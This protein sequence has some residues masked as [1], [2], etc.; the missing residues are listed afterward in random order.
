MNLAELRESLEFLF[1]PAGEI[2]LVMY[3][4]VSTEAGF[5]ARQADITE[6]V[7]V[8][9]RDQFLSFIQEKFMVNQELHFADI[10]VADNRQ[11]SAYYFDLDE[12]PTGLIVMGDLMQDEAAPV[13]DFN[14]DDYESVFGFV[15]LLGNESHKVGLYKKHYPI[16]LLKRDS[17]L[18]LFKVGTRLVEVPEDIITLTEKVDFLQVGTEIVVINTNTLEKFFGFDAIVRSQAEVSIG[19]IEAA[20]FLSDVS[21]LQDMAVDLRFA[22]KLMRVKADS[23]VLQL[24]FARVRE[25]IKQHPQLKRR[26]RFNAD[27]SRISLDTKT[28]KQLFLKLLDDDF[29]K[30]DLTQFLYETEIKSRLSNEEASD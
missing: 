11:N 9:L 17:I 5:V 21:A 20:N 27:E 6:E 29:L 7:R 25:F 30:S 12:L 23:P 24:P 19:I 4:V 18:R 13:F 26:I 14:T 15:F 8:S 28:S 22:K 16:N 10:T 1:D 2:G 3:F